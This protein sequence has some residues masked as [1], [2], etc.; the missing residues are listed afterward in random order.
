[1]DFPEI[2]L[3]LAA[4]KL[5]GRIYQW[6]ARQFDPGWVI[7]VGSELGLGASLMQAENAELAIVGCDVN[8]STLKMSRGRATGSAQSMVQ[9]DGSILPFSTTS[10]SGV[11]LINILHLVEEPQL[12]CYE[13]YRTLKVGGRVV[14]SVDMAKLPVRWEPKRLELALDDILGTQFQFIG[15]D[16]AT[17]ILSKDH[18]MQNVDHTKIYLRLAEKQ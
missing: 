16:G 10:L 5:H 1:M 17:P 2:D 13:A 12:L 15:Q 4:H 9:A 6:S 14:V 3:D 18:S 11:C 8:F 7:D